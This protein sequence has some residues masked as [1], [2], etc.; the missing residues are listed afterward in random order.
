LEEKNQKAGGKQTWKGKSQ[1]PHQIQEPWWPKGK[2][3]DPLPQQISQ[4]KTLPKEPRAVTRLSTPSPPNLPLNQN[5]Q[6]VDTVATGIHTFPK[7]LH[8]QLIITP[9]DRVQSL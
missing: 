8:R 2:Q 5:F 4:P 6:N 9:A 3:P 1:G 7:S